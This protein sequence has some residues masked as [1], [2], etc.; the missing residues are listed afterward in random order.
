MEEE[1]KD[2]KRVDGRRRMQI[3]A[4][5]K[6]IEEDVSSGRRWAL[7]GIE[8]TE[9][10]RD[11]GYEI[12][13]EF[14][15]LAGYAFVNSNDLEGLLKLAE[16]KPG[17]ARDAVMLSSSAD[18]GMKKGLADYLVEKTPFLALEIY[19]EIKDKKGIERAQQREIEKNPEGAFF[20][21]VG[22]MDRWHGHSVLKW[23]DLNKAGEVLEKLIE[24]D[25]GVKYL[26]GEGGL[27]SNEENPIMQC[28]DYIFR[29]GTLSPVVG[30]WK[31]YEG[32]AKTNLQ[33]VILFYSEKVDQ[34][35]KEH[36]LL[37]CKKCTKAYQKSEIVPESSVHWEAVWYDQCGPIAGSEDWVETTS[38]SCPKCSDTIYTIK[39][40]AKDGGKGEKKGE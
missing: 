10:L 6:Q 18:K 21:L 37:T 32:V 19:T 16:R 26:L 30:R 15:W 14:P 24:N 11:I 38:Y 5:K 40:L 27:Y 13:E 3:R 1:K 22:E 31:V 28:E 4:L 12:I 17:D 8:D 39:T 34:L 35:K 9:I 25:E 36:G 20:T 7:N 33:K 29:I 23:A 2:E